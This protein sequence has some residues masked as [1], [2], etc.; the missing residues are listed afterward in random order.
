MVITRPVQSKRKNRIGVR[1]DMKSENIHSPTK[2]GNVSFVKPY[3]E[4]E[5]DKIPRCL[6]RKRSHFHLQSPRDSNVSFCQKDSL[7]S[8]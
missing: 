7:V 4:Y 8:N 5:Y 6:S 1:V 2:I 3:P